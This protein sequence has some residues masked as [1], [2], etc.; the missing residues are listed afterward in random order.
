MPA[1]LDVRGLR[2]RYGPIVAVRDASLHVEEGEIVALLG[3][4]GAGKTTTLGAIAG[5]VRD[6]DR[7][8]EPRDRR[9]LAPTAGAEVGDGEEGAARAL[10]RACAP[11]VLAGGHALRRRAAAARD[12]ALAD[13]KAAPAAPRRADARPRA[14]ARPARLRADR[15]AAHRARAHRSAR[16]AERPPRPRPLRPRLR[17]EAGSDRG[18]GHSG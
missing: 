9:R 2:A 7:G 11:A 10:P 17:H 4:N 8:R 18:R 3:A 6:P 1:L 5:L 13:V 14:E 15:A 16:R 12:R